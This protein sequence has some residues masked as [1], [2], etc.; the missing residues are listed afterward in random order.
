MLILIIVVLVITAL[1]I[2]LTDLIPMDGTLKL[3]IKILI[4][5]V[6]IIAIATKSGLLH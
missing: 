5:I 6:A 3:I 2:Y 1:C 4:I